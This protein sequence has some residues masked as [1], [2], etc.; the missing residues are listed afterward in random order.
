MLNCDCF[1][2]PKT[3]LASAC[4]AS[5]LAMQAGLTDEGNMKGLS[6][7]LNLSELWLQTVVLKVD[8]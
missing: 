1:K 7:G 3:P 6:Q 2:L 4:R 5:E 8:S